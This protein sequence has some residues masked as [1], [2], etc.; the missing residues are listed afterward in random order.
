M[1]R[2]QS[3]PSLNFTGTACPAFTVFTAG[4]LETGARKPLNTGPGCWISS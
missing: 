3:P 4:G 1:F 2:P